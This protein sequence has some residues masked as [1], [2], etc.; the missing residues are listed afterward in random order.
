MIEL[1]I[2]DVDRT[3]TRKPTYSLF[4][5]HAMRRHAPWRVILTPI[6][7]PAALAYAGGLITRTRMKE[8]MHWVALGRSLAGEEAEILAEEF[9]TELYRDGLYPQ[10]IERIEAER[11]AGR[12]VVLATAAPSLYI[13]PLA[14]HLAIADVVATG[15]LRRG[16]I[17]THRIAGTNCYGAHKL[18]MIIDALE[19]RKIDR[20]KAHVR[21]FTDHASDRDVCEWADEAFAV[22]PSPKM[23]AL[24]QLK[25]WPVIDWRTA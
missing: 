10:A 5:L 18:T 11:K 21:F 3:I 9:A 2:F 14:K 8:C 13:A 22:N 6:L 15:A 19:A 20:A 4:L 24:A 12:T 17:L 25:G 23:L 16:D 1:S 7:I